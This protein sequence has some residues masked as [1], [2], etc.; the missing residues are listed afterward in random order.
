[1]YIYRGEESLRMGLGVRGEDLEGK[2]KRTKRKG[3]SRKVVIHKVN[4]QHQVEGVNPSRSCLGTC[5][6]LV[7]EL[8]IHD[9]VSTEYGVGDA[10]W[11]ERTENPVSRSTF[12]LNLR[13]R[14]VEESFDYYKFTVSSQRRFV[15]NECTCSFK[16]FGTLERR[17]SGSFPSGPV[18]SLGSSQWLLVR[19][20]RLSDYKSY[21]G[22][23][24]ELVIWVFT[25]R[26]SLKERDQSGCPCVSSYFITTLSC[27]DLILQSLDWRLDRKKWS[28][29]THTHSGNDRL[30]VKGVKN[31]FLKLDLVEVYGW[32][33][34]D[35]VITRYFTIQRRFSYDLGRSQRKGVK[36][37]HLGQQK[38]VKKGG[39]FWWKTV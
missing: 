38:E 16:G 13:L 30:G 2:R 19:S 11:G 34:R 12:K 3:V 21:W 24:S 8:F 31:F 39:V 36:E 17:D 25:K 22:P 20:L 4:K 6:F 28:I 18:V 23:E 26:R 1:M 35:F 29:D 37:V 27:P 10:K 5:L 14:S 15:I 9:L 7:R 33:E 32:K